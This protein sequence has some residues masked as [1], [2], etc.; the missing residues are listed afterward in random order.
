MRKPSIIQTEKKSYLSGRTDSL[1]PHEP[2]GGKNKRTSEKEG[3]WIWVT[4]D[5]H[6]WIHD[7]EEGELKDLEYSAIMQEAWLEHT[8]KSKADWYRLFYKYYE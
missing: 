8:G 4:F 6:R 1:T 3:L 5:E 2:I 7:T